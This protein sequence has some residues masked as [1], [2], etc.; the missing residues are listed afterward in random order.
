MAQMQGNGFANVAANGGD[1]YASQ[2]GANVRAPDVQHHSAQE[3]V[4]M[5]PG[6]V[7]VHSADMSGQHIHSGWY[8]AIKRSYSTTYSLD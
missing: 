5:H 4:V 8:E 7:D 2:A 1:G 3:N 6:V